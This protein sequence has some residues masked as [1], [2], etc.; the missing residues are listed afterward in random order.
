M[1]IKYN[2]ADPDLGYDIQCFLT[3][4][5]RSGISFYRILS[6]NF[7]G[8]ENFISQSIGD[9]NFLY[10]FKNKI[11]FYFVKFM[12]ANKGKTTNIYP[13]LFVVDGPRIWDPKIQDPRSGIWDGKKSE[14]GNLR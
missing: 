5:S 13:S 12:A 7:W 9:K 4:G 11:I 2:I 10:L 6:N 1:E 14:F 3:H 8:K